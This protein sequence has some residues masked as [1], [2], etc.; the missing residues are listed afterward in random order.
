MYRLRYHLRCAATQLNVE[1]LVPTMVL[2]LVVIAVGL[3][4]SLVVHLATFI[5]V[6]FRTVLPAVMWLHVGSILAGLPVVWI[7]QRLYRKVPRKELWKAA[8]RCAPKWMTKTM[9]GVFAYALLTFVLMNFVFNHG[10]VPSE[11]DGR[12]VLHSHGRVIRYLSDQEFERHQ[13]YTLRSFSA[14]WLAFYTIAFTVLYSQ[15][16]ERNSNQQLE[17]TRPFST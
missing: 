13:L 17:Q 8:T 1:F 2:G 16:Q 10:G 5:G 6:D 4:F 9:M 12:K 7:F 14:H 3:I 15:M 11:L